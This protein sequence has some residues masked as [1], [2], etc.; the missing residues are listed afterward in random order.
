[1]CSRDLVLRG[2]TALSVGD[3]DAAAR[4]F[5]ESLTTEQSYD[6]LVQKSRAL[7]ELSNFS[8]ALED[9]GKAIALDAAR[10]EAYVAQGTYIKTLDNFIQQLSR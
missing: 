6:I 4:L 1:M 3:Y 10:P 9:S 7:T 2:S 5:T 8:S